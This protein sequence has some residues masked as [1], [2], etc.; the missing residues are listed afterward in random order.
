MGKNGNGEGTIH[1][2]KSG[3]AGW[4]AQYFADVGGVKKRRTIYA[5]TRAEAA[6]KLA[7]AIADRDGGL[8]VDSGKLTVG[9]YLDG[10]LRDAVQ[11]TVRTCS[12]SASD[13]YSSAPVFHRSAS[14]T[15]A[16][17]ARRSSCRRTSI[18]NTSRSC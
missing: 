2:R 3:G 15:C 14:T 1:K 17:P 5:R 10:W 16:I 12:G 9:D 18:L 13:R 11:G 4:A 6:A 8:V 7:K